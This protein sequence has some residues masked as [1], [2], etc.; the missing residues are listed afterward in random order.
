MSVAV[1][2]GSEPSARQPSSPPAFDPDRFLNSPQRGQTYGGGQGVTPDFPGRGRPYP[3]SSARACC[4]PGAPGGCP[5][6]PSTVWSRREKRETASSF[7]MMTV[8]RSSRPREL[9][10]PPPSPHPSP[11]PLE[12]SGRVGRGRCLEELEGAA[13]RP[14][15]SLSS[16]PDLMGELIS[17][18]AP[19]RP[20]PR[21]QLSPALST[22]TDF[23]P[24]GPTQR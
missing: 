6:S 11:A 22:I 12:P 7:R 19:R 13:A 8:E 21:P 14:L 3:L 17:D 10:H 23:S 9:P 18:E 15:F 5:G 20:R 1:V 2:V 24:G 4:C 16:F